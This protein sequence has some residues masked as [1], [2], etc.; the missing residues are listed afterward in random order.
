MTYPNSNTQRSFVLKR[1]NLAKKFKQ[2]GQ[3][4]LSNNMHHCKAM[5]KFSSEYR[6]NFLLKR[7]YHSW[8]PRV[9]K[10]SIGSIP[11]ID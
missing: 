9:K 11:I 6:G 5:Y 1:E 2:I 8:A 10:T 4:R 3:S 7:H